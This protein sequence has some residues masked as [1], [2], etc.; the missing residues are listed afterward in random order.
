MSSYPGFFVR[1]QLGDTPD[2]PG[3]GPWSDT[4]D[5]VLAGQEPMLAAPLT[6]QQGYA[7]DFGA[8]V[9]TGAPNFIYVRALDAGSAALTGRVWLYTAPVEAILYPPLWSAAGISVAGAHANYQ[10]IAAS[11][12][13]EIVQPEL[14][15]VLESVAAR[16]GS[17]LVSVIWIENEPSETPV[18][19][20]ASLPPFTSVEAFAA[21]VRASPNV[22]VRKTTCQQGAQLTWVSVTGA[23]TG[24]DQPSQLLLG[25]RCKNMPTD[26]SVGFAAPGPS[27][28]IGPSMLPLTAIKDPDMV[29]VL[30]TIWPASAASSIIVTYRQ[31]A[32]PPPP[33]AHIMAVMLSKETGETLS[34]TSFRVPALG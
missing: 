18:S 2:R 17:V 15:F 1:D 5:I 13:G 22:G 20:A 14:P 10:T 9:F 29:L 30:P 23:L 6:S 21:F 25:V 4:P 31:G 3:D 28:S 34:S 24:P 7:R 26:G 27:P 12:G 11:R 33:N 8:E 32:T 19:P 16:P